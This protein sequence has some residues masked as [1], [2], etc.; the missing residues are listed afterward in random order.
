MWLSDNA[1]ARWP[2]DEFRC[3]GQDL[4]ISGQIAGLS[5]TARFHKQ[6]ANQV[7]GVAMSTCSSY[8]GL[9]GSSIL[10]RKRFLCHVLSGDSV[11]ELIAAVRLGGLEPTTN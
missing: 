7:I 9:N 8:L 4:A 6:R 3:G 10:L 5:G 11:A 2:T 1:I